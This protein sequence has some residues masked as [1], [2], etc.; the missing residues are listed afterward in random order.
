M[1]CADSVL[2]WTTHL[3]KEPLR[4]SG[5]S[6]YALSIRYCKWI[7]V[8]F[9]RCD[10]GMTVIVQIKMSSELHIEEFYNSAK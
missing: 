4:Q 9:V 6:D 1:Q 5:K 7:I 8:N 3:W 2:F 10:S